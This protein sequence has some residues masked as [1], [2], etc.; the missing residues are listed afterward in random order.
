MLW[1]L[2]AVGLLV[3]SSAALAM[4]GAKR[5]P[6]A[7][8]PPVAP[9]PV[10]ATPPE[11]SSEP[12]PA[13]EHL[14][15]LAGVLLLERGGRADADGLL[16][17][18]E[19][20]E[21]AG[22]ARWLLALDPA[23]GGERWRRP[24]DPGIA[25]ESVLR[26][27]L[28][29]TLVVALPQE[30][31]GLEPE[32]GRTVWQRVPSSAPV[33]ACVH[34][35]DFGLLDATHSLSAY[36]GTT[37]SPLAFGPS[38]CSPAY[39]SSADAPNFEFVD[40]S[41]AARWLPREPRLHPLRGLSP[42]Q[43]TAEVVLG[44]EADSGSASLAVVTRQRLLWQANVANESPA[45]ARWTSPPLASVRLERVVVP[46]VWK[47]SLLLS[48]FDLATGERR[49]TTPL[50]SPSG[51]VDDV[52][53]GGEGALA[54]SRGGHVAYRAPTGELFGLDLDTGAIEW[55]LGGDA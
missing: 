54:I 8:A 38:A 39:D 33:R 18:A 41:V 5:A 17:L 55:K 34:G 9:T 29:D 50:P 43:G 2:V 44:T 1:S 22:R 24:L 12:E 13:R 49:W 23:T 25:P 15:V 36:S 30:L 20:P 53:A 27:P 14:R 10:T 40:A 6:P 7:P 26:L 37:G 52:A 48:A 21:P 42:H 3:L 11:L 47:R 46:Y 19:A 45:L 31:W 32:S 16:V 35:R 4:L 51:G 28:G